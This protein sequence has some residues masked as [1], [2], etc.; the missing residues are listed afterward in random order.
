MKVYFPP[1]IIQK[2]KEYSLRESDVWDVINH[3]EYLTKPNGTKMI[4]R[5]YKSL[6][7][8]IGILYKPHDTYDYIILSVWKQARR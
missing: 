1:Q 4:V 2:L 7:Y 8:E 3:G 5:H 6:G